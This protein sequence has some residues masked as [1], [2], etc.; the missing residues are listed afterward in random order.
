MEDTDALSTGS[1]VL[2]PSRPTYSARGMVEYGTQNARARKLKLKI[3][4]SL[5]D[6]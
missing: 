4:G 3:E 6:P 5:Y 1:G 2:T